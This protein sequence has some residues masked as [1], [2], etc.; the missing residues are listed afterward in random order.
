[1]IQSSQSKEKKGSNS[2]NLVSDTS[3]KNI[4]SFSTSAKLVFISILGVF[5]YFLLT[6]VE[7]YVNSDYFSIFI[8]LI[9][10]TLFFLWLAV[11]YIFF[12]MTASTLEL[13]VTKK[14]F[15]LLLIMGALTA[16]FAVV[17]NNKALIFASVVS[18][19]FEQFGI[20][21]NTIPYVQFN[22]YVF[23]I[24]VIEEV[25][26]IFP[27]IV[28]LGNY[29]Q[30]TFQKK[31]IQTRLTPSLRMFVLYG[32]F[33]GVWFDLFE[34][35]FHF[36]NLLAD[37][38]PPQS[39]VNT[40]IYTRSVFPLHCVTTM[41]ASLGLGIVFINRKNLR[42]R[43]Q[44]FLF[45]LFVLLSACLHGL[46]NYYSISQLD[47]SS[48]YAALSTIGYVSIGIY[49]IFVMFLLLYKPKICESCNTE[50]ASG[51][52][53]EL[54]N[55]IEEISKTLTKRKK[56]T[57][58]LQNSHDMILCSECQNKTYNGYFCINCWSFPKLQCNNCNQI[59]PSYTRICW[60][61][62]TEVPTLY[63]KMTSSSPSLHVSLSV[64]LT[65]ILGAGM[66][67]SFIFA[68]A[69]LRQ[70]I[71]TIG[72]LSSMGYIILLLGIIL[73]LLV[74]IMW[75]AYSSNRVKSMI[76]SMNLISIAAIAII[77]TGLYLSV[78][79][80]LMIITVA[81]IVMGLI[82]LTCVLLIITLCVLYLLKI[83]K[84]ARLIVT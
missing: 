13:T 79:A 49:A 75:Y 31:R 10:L 63:T 7:R 65:R 80:F 46:W 36:S 30:F 24:P 50:H 42:K 60:S 35:F 38:V 67:V 23:I 45:I 70:T 9:I 59:L 15:T 20:V 37:N 34:Q 33:F 14:I 17:I 53:I 73:S 58:L 57:P 76:S 1:M 61:C 66:F 64:G 22:F 56:I 21:S 4:L 43:F 8:V 62:G 6:S 32:A 26:K 12:S 40:L 29:A 41:I 84:G 68:F 5:I 19:F 48:T 51:S 78:F 39:I 16:Y 55:N 83:I 69:S 52:C 28:L 3:Y 47:P 27:L 25:A 18:S 54:N 2:L 81:Q 77:I 71:F 72:S 74:T 44:V 11:V 82:G